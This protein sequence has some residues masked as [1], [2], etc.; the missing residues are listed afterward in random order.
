MFDALIKGGTVVDGAGSPPRLADVAIKDGLIVAVGPNINGEAAAIVDAE[1][2]LVTPGFIDIHTHYDGQVTWDDA[3]LPSSAHGVTTVVFGNCG[4][5]FAPVRK[6]T[7]DWLVTL[8]EGVEDIPGGVLNEGIK[9]SWETFPEYLNLLASRRYALDLAALL[10]H[11][12]VRGYVMRDRATLDN[13]AT[14]ADLEQITGIVGDAIRAGAVGIGTSRIGIHQGSDGSI[15]P[16]FKSSENELVAIA[17]AMRDAGG[18]VFQMVPSGVAGNVEGVDSN[19]NFGALGTRRDRHLLTAEVAMMRRM[20]AASGQPI[21]FS[22]SE[23]RGL[24]KSEFDGVRELVA[25]ARKAG[26]PIYP[27]FSVRPTMILSSLGAYHAFMGR[28][29]YVRI[30]DLPLHERVAKMRDPAL[31]A[32]I[33]SET[34]LEPTSSE[35]MA[36]FHIG[37][38]RATMDMYELTETPD[39]EPPLSQSMAALARAEGREPL[40]Y[41]YDAYLKDD[42]KAVIMVIGSNYLEGDLRLTE[43]LLQDP[44]FVFGLGDAGAHV[45]AISDGSIPTFCLMHW[46]RDRTRG[47]TLPIELIVK[48]LTRD[49]A[50]LYGFEDRGVIEVGRRADI[51]VIDLERLS[52]NRPHL[53]PDL[54]SNGERFLQEATGY[55]LT[56][57]AG[58]VTR[59]NDQDTGARPGR[60]VRNLRSAKQRRLQTENDRP[61]GVI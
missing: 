4:I 29:S 53:V 7:E 43:K 42:G 44:N 34:D 59:R 23:S 32:A 1:G 48:R 17:E 16:S 58:V 30:A 12:A 60:L 39:Y 14:E 22:F 26:E 5:G 15:L 45:R 18:G 41:L 8:M 9:W 20:C 46:S 52:I 2:K 54:P 55:D 50:K 61:A 19:S 3:M 40:E 27:Q 13:P 49:N 21:T 28:P 57:V 51:N 37:L 6:G 11:S 25:E 56:M 47:K 33:L 36:H 24:D 38:Q 35:P 10:P 31:K